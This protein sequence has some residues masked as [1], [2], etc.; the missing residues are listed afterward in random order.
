MGILPPIFFCFTGCVCS[1]DWFRMLISSRVQISMQQTS[2]TQA[3]GHDG[4]ID[5]MS[6]FVVFW[7]LCECVFRQ[8]HALWTWE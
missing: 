3:R 7:R 4:S 1:S 8:I 5:P 2:Y 6:S